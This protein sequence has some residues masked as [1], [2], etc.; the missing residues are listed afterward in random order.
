TAT[1]SERNLYAM[2]TP[3]E[4][5]SCGSSNS[6]AGPADVVS[7]FGLPVPPLQ[8]GLAEMLAEL[9]V[10]ID[11]SDYP[12]CLQVNYTKLILSQ[13]RYLPLAREAASESRPFYS[14]SSRLHPWTRKR[15]T[16]ALL[17]SCS[18]RPPIACAKKLRSLLVSASRTRRH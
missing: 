12:V 16:I 6:A 8:A 2:L 9:L 7:D 4:L 10:A 5:L 3:A 18:P 14:T 13:F 15:D 1:E 17:P 11:K